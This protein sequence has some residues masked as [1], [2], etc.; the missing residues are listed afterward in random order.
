MKRV[1]GMLLLAVL[2]IP[3]FLIMFILGVYQDLKNGEVYQS[4]FGSLS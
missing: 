1:A 3:A 2:A 4:P